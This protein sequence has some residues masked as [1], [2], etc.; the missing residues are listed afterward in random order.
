ML[1]KLVDELKALSERLKK[2]DCETKVSLKEKGS[3]L[4]L[5]F[6]I[7]YPNYISEFFQIINKEKNSFL[8]ASL[9]LT[10]DD[11]GENG[12]RNWDLSE[13]T[14]GESYPNLLSFSVEKTL[15]EH[16]NRSIITGGDSYDE[17]GIIGKVLDK[18]PKLEHLYL[19]SVPDKRFFSRKNHP[20]KTLKIQVSYEN[21][22]FISNLGN[23]NSFKNLSVLEFE[24]YA[25]TYMENYMENCIPVNDYHNFFNS[26]YLKNLK[27]VVFINT[28]LSEVDVGK[29]KKSV[30][31]KRLDKFKVIKSK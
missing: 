25:E 3:F 10:G 17:G 29:L 28:Q 21:K 30:V 23:S 24:D 13:L 31:G 9:N 12:S 16:L 27:E 15:P 5:N 26:K 4:E 22:N 19:P 1:I 6:H 2:R 18:M 8:L 11:N 14:N 20:L 7:E